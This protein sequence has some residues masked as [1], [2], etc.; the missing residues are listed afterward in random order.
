M[1][2]MSDMADANGDHHPQK[3]ADCQLGQACRGSVAVAPTPP[4]LKVAV[5]KLDQARPAF[6][7]AEPPPALVFSFWR[8]PRTV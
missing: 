3:P 4:S 6:S 2:E 7:A 1:A 8:P 5:I